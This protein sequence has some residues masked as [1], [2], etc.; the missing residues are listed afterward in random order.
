[1]IK[2]LQARECSAEMGYSH[3]WFRCWWDQRVVVH[4]GPLH[5]LCGDC[6]LSPEVYRMGWV[7]L[8]G[9]YKENVE[10]STPVLWLQRRQQC[11]LIKKPAHKMD[12]SR[13]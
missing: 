8:F 5:W 12:C 6:Q 4:Y 13:R 9:Y 10:T 1:M 11:C 2:W 7:E 3:S